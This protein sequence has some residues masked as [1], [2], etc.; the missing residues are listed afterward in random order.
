M[1]T[2]SGFMTGLIEGQQAQQQS[3]LSKLA[4]Q[5]GGLKV[6]SEEI[7]VQSAQMML[8]RQRQFA[9]SLMKMN[10]GGAGPGNQPTDQ[11]T[12]LANKL[13]AM[14]NA[15]IDAGLPEEGAGYLEKASTLEKN[16]S[17]ITKAA[18]ENQIKSA[19]LMSSLVKDLQPGDTRGF[20]QAVMMWQGITGQQARPELLQGEFTQHTKDHLLSA[21]QTV[22]QKAQTQLDQ[23]RAGE[24]KA[25][26]R[27]ADATVPLRK[28]QTEAAEQRTDNLRKAGAVEKAPTAK[29]LAAITVLG[30]HDFPDVDNQE[31]SRSTRIH[32][33][34]WMREAQDKGMSFEASAQYAYKKAKAAGDFQGMRGGV[35]MAGSSAEKPL[36]ITTMKDKSGKTRIDPSKVKENQWYKDSK[37]FGDSKPRL[38]VDGQ[39]WTQSELDEEAEQTGRSLEPD[40]IDEQPAQ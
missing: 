26:A 40:D 22:L 31:L 1:S 16:Q 2:P 33:I 35:G 32:A 30:H 5:E 12:Q 8:D 27:V 23:A 15:A 29:E 20:H 3:E 11:A 6:Q 9:Q 14:G 34:Q 7:A 10:S 37:L 4:I 36:P 19:S 21:G 13:Y 28:V 18:L 39:F 25:Q 38:L 17:A 24:A